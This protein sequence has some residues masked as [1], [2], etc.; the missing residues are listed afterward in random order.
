MTTIE[1]NYHDIRQAIACAC[2]HAGR[3]HEQVKIVAVSKTVGPAQI[4][5]AIAAGVTCFAENRTS[6]FKERI[7]MFPQQEWHFIGTIQTNKVK[8]FAGRA[9]LVHSVSSEHALQAIDARMALMEAVW[10]QAREQEQEQ[11]QASLE[12]AV[13]IEVNVSGEESKDGVEPAG[14][15]GLLCIASTLKHITVQGLMTI[16]PI[17]DEGRIRA[18]FSGLRELREATAPLFSSSRN[19]R[20]SELSMGMTDDYVIAVEEGATIVR[21]GRALWG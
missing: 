5:E 9:A 16:A 13:L 20:L 2:A 11:E 3:V 21:I 1:Q 8:D 10:E 4:N 14:L 17:G 12:Q 6:L 15:P 18:V 19:I 7:A